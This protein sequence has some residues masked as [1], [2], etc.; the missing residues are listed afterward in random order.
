M[1]ERLRLGLGIVWTLALCGAEVAAPPDSAALTAKIDRH[2]EAG[3]KA[4]GVTPAAT[5]SDSEFLRRVYLDLAGHIPHVAKVRDFLDDSRPDKR[6]R[7]VDELLDGP[8]YVAHFGTVWRR[9]WLPQT[10][11]NPQFQFFGPQFEIW[12]RRQLRQ[13]VAYDK[14]VRDLLTAPPGASFG[15]QPYDASTP[16]PSAFLDVNETKAENVAAA[17]ARLFLG[18]KIECAQCHNHPFE[19]WTRQQFWEFASFFAGLTPVDAQ[20]FRRAP[21]EAVE[22]RSLTIPDTDKKVN[23]RFLDGKLPTFKEKV[24]SR[25]TLADWMTAKDNPYFARNAANRMWAQFFGV[26]LID[27]VDEPGDSNPPSHPELLDDLAKSFAESNFDL[28]YLIRAIVNSKAYQL[29]SFAP[30]A[31]ST[32]DRTFARMRV[33]GLTPEQLFD[34]L[35]LATYFADEDTQASRRQFGVNGPARAGILAKFN[36]TERPSEVQTSILQALTLMNGKFIG[37]LTSLDEK[38]NGTVAAIDAPFFTTSQKI[39]ALYL[40]VL[41]RKP[42]ADELAKLTTYV[43]KG[44]PGGDSRK[45]LADVFWALLNSSEFGFNH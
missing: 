13:N 21:V 12:L 2:I 34:S 45:A 35:A 16:P 30:G 33:R 24:S 29:S 31:S 6:Q 23:A 28:K 1:T 26:G 4:N 14:V 43:D 19:T 18:V 20:R 17:T 27:P 39:E 25:V 11:N 37:D 38:K 44:G 32:G 36:S 15:G 3:W 41:S 7:I 10:V 5:S 40:A 42:A 9:E 8:G 22:I